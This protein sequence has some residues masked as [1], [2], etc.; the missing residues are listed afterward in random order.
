MIIR[1]H[2][3]LDHK[4]MNGILLYMYCLLTT[5]TCVVVLG[6]IPVFLVWYGIKFRLVLLYKDT[7]SRYF[8]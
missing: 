5:E 6:C 4:I 2:S 7:V 3:S 1:I 8:N